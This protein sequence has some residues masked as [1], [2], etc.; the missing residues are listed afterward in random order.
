MNKYIK[1][2]SY[3]L[4]LSLIFTTQISRA[5]LIKQNLGNNFHTFGDIGQQWAVGQTFIAE[6]PNVI[7][8]FDFV[9]R[10]INANPSQWGPN[11]PI[12]MHLYNIGEGAFNGENLVNE[13]TNRTITLT[14][15][16]NGFAGFDFSDINLQLGSTYAAFVTSPGNPS[17]AFWEVRYGV[18]SGYSGGTMIRNTQY[19]VNSTSFEIFD[20]SDLRFRIEPVLTSVPV[21]SAAILLISGLIGLLGYIKKPS[22]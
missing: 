13:V 19:E 3:I 6:D 12:T 2:S 16:Y 10:D 4:L 7:I 17:G 22:S 15:N 9:P 21:P 8:S 18:P 1:L 11:S 20:N 5:E 14:D